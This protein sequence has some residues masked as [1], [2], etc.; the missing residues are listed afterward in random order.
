MKVLIVSNL[1]YH[2]GV[3]GG[4][5]MAARELVERLVANGH[6]VV[7]ATLNPRPRHEVAEID[8]VRVHYLPNR[9][10]YLYGP[11]K[12]RHVATSALWHALDTY[13]PLMAISLG[14]VLDAER[15]DVV[16]THNI[17]GFSVAA[18]HAVKK[19]RLPLVHKIC[20]Y[21]VLCPRGMFRNRRSCQE[22]CRV[23]RV[24]GRPRRRLSNMV[25]VVIGVSRSALE[26]HC[27]NDCFTH[28]EKMVVYTA[29]S[30]RRTI[31]TRVADG[32]PIIRFGFLGKLQPSKGIDL[33]IRS[34]LELPAGSAELFI[35][36]RGTADYEN[37]LKRSTSGHPGV[38]W[39]GFTSPEDLLQ[40]VDVLVV[41]SLWEEPAARVVREGMAHGVP[42]IGS[43]RGGTPE[44]MGDGT[45]WV[46]DPEVPG[47]LTRA[48]QCAID[49]RDEL[50]AMGER[51][52]ERARNF[53]TEAMV[54]GYLQAY[55]LAIE[56][57]T[58]GGKGR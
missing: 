8:G 9:N 58:K 35:A 29:C 13:N 5:E 15:P 7:V 53:S 25:D 26:T 18:W 21:Y 14:R 3:F 32:N 30:V 54:Q 43:C 12:R 23:C 31:R 38:R 34:F 28:S 11:P 2:P 10:I 50:A 17:A 19:R 4:A 51:A 20:D 46:F 22:V 37:H 55:S 45:G 33:L 27:R 57:S 47:M 6:E 48:M 42:L 1:L 41:P 49:S 36:G 56:K 39:L 52:C 16:N 24:G 40:R 44:Q